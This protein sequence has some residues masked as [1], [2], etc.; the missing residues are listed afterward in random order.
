MGHKDPHPRRI[1]KHSGVNPSRHSVLT[2]K[3]QYC[4]CAE[5]TE[6]VEKN[7]CC[8]VGP[9]C[10]DVTNF[11]EDRKLIRHPLNG[12]LQVGWSI[13]LPLPPLLQNL[14]SP[15]IRGFRL[16]SSFIVRV[17]RGVIRLGRPAKM[18]LKIS[19]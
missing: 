10:V 18:G 9:L 16:S 7:P 1:A 4:L 14:M 11:G 12:N 13:P 19:S 8:R 17:G 3:D 5:G 6:R 2:A 15:L